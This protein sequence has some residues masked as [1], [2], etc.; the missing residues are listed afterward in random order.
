MRVGKDLAQGPRQRSEGFLLFFFNPR[1]RICFVLIW[2]RENNIAFLHTPTK[3]QTQNPGMCP[4][5]LQP[6]GALDDAPSHNGQCGV[7]DLIGGG[8]PARKAGGEK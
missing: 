8:V 6:F 1:P 2:E 3:D 7:R 5:H 4:D